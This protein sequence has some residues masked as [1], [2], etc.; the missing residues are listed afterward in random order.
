VRYCHRSHANACRGNVAA[1]ATPWAAV[2]PS[3]DIDG[4]YVVEEQ[5]RIGEGVKIHVI[6]L[7]WCPIPGP[8]FDALGHDCWFGVWYYLRVFELSASSAAAA[9]ANNIIERQ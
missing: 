8:W 1:K 6:F 5:R 4:A 7:P 2:D 3:Y 9:A